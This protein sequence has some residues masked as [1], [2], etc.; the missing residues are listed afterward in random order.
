MER[1]SWALGVST[2][3]PRSGSS[4][5]AIVGS[6]AMASASSTTIVCAETWSSSCDVNAVV[7]GRSAR[8]GP[9]SE[10]VCLAHGREQRIPVVGAG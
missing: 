4:R 7:A 10:R 1:T 5:E 2:S 8:P 3:R 9:M 6:T